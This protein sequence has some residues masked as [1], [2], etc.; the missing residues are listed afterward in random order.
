MLRYPRDGQAIESMGA[1]NV[2]RAASRRA[3]RPVRPPNAAGRARA[4]KGEGATGD[5]EP[6]LD[7]L[8]H[9]VG[10]AA[11]TADA[12]SWNRGIHIAFWKNGAWKYAVPISHRREYRDM[13]P[14][15]EP[16]EPFA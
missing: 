3:L 11:A 5:G 16:E 8:L 1:V 13:V 14:T 12:H 10:T 2:P 9:A 15:A 4:D 6:A 7:I